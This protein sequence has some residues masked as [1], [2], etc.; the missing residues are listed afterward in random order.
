MQ[1][2][3]LR[4]FLP[5]AHWR[6][7]FTLQRRHTYP[8]P[9]YSTVVGL[10]CN[11]LGIRNGLGEGVPDHPDF[12]QIAKLQMAI[13]GQF[14]A[15][16]TEYVWFRNL[17]KKA[18]QERFFSPTRR[19]LQGEV[20]HP[21][22]Q[23]PIRID[24]LKDVEV[25]VALRHDKAPDF[26]VRLQQAFQNP[27]RRLGP[28][29]L[30]R[31]EDWIVYD[32]NQDIQLLE[33]DATCR[34]VFG[35]FSPYFFWVPTRFSPQIPLG[36]RY[37][38]TTLYQLCGGVRQFQFQEVYLSEGTFTARPAPQAQ[39]VAIPWQDGLLRK[40]PLFWSDSLHGNTNLGKE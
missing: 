20:E 27:K 3:L 39:V 29:H 9:P 26:L 6:V 34:P 40:V 22:G 2:L 5:Q 38:I 13:W 35:R 7:P 33:V 24:V 10:L 23:S 19:T 28:L 4:L 16:V 37:S 11:V 21:G 18:H 8:L 31:A 12:L 32:P 15:K 17:A 36:L 14:E 1:V 30:G 25:W